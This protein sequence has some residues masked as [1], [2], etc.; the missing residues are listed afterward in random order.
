[1]ALTAAQLL[2]ARHTVRD[3]M[4]ANGAVV[5]IDKPTL[6]LVLTTATTWV[7]NNA[8][9]FNTAMAGTALNTQTAAVKAAVLAYVAL[10]RYG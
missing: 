2:I 7:E 10:A 4:F 5:N 9:S 8:P 6:D 3:L 1:M